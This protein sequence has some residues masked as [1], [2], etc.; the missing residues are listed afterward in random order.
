MLALLQQ[1]SEEKLDVM[2]TDD[3]L[4]LGSIYR[5]EDMRGIDPSCFNHLAE[6]EIIKYTKHGVEPANGGVMLAIGNQ[7]AAIADK[8][9]IEINECWSIWRTMKQ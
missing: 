1:I 7:S 5:G 8:M 2:S 4:L 3:Y 6:L 9:P